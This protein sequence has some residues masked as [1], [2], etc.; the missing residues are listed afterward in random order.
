MKL[1][2]IVLLCSVG[3][4]SASQTYSQQTKLD[5]LYERVS[6]VK[7]LEDLRTQTGYHFFYFDGVVPQDVFVTIDLRQANINEILNEILVKNGFTYKI[8]E[9]TVSIGRAQTPHVQTPRVQTPQAAVVR[10]KVTEPDGTPIIGVTVA[11]KGMRGGT[12]TDANGN[13]TL[14]VPPAD[15]AILVFS[16]IGKEL[17]EVAYTGQPEIT[18]TMKDVAAAIQEV[19]VTGIF[20]RRRDSF[21]GSSNTIS[22]EEL[23][24]LSS[25]NILRAVEMLDPGFRMDVNNMYGSN[26]SVIPQFQMRGQS[27][28]GD[29]STDGDVIFRGDLDTHPN[30]PLFVLD[31]MIVEVTKIIDLDPAQ[32]QSVTVLKDAAAMVLYGSRGANGI[33][34][35]E[36]KSPQQGSLRVSYNGNYKYLAPNLNGYNLLNAAEKLQLEKNAGIYEAGTTPAAINRLYNDYRFRMLDVLRGVDTYW[37]AKPL[38]SAFN[39]RHGLNLEGGDNTLRYKLYFGVNSAPGVMKKT[40]VE[41]KSGSIDLRYRYKGLLVSNVMFVDHTVSNRTSPYGNFTEYA[42]MNP[43]YRYYDLNGNMQRYLETYYNFGMEY[44]GSGGMENPAWDSLLKQKNQN[45]AFEVRNIFRAEYLV[46]ENLR[47]TFDATISRISSDTDVFLPAEHSSFGSATFLTPELRGS[48]SWTHNTSDSFNTSLMASYNK[49]F[50]RHL[51]AVFARAE[52][53]QRKVRI[54]NN[55]ATGFPNENMDDIFLGARANDPT[56]SESTYRSI[57]TVGT[58]SYSYD[59]RYAFDF[60]GRID[61][62]S[63]FGRNNRFAPFW[64]TGLRWNAHNENFLR[65]SK[66]INELVLRGTYGITG[67]Q[68]F[69]PYQALQMYTYDNMMYVYNGSDVLGT[70]IRSLGN[71]DLKWQKTDNYNLG[72]DFT[73]FDRI[74]SGRFEYYYKY[75]KNT[76]LDFSLAPSIGFTEIVDNMGNISNEG[77]EVTLRVMPYNNP[78]RRLNVSIVAMGGHNKN[79]IR[80]ISNALRVRNEESRNSTTDRPLPR[81]EEGY[82]MSRIWVVKSLGIDPYDG[83]EVFLTRDGRMTNIYNSMDQIPYGDTEPTLRGSLN[84]NVNWKGF[85]LTMGNRYQFGGQLFNQTLIDKVE[86][87]NLRYNV[88]RRALTE[89]W[90]SQGE[91]TAFKGVS[92]AAAGQSTRASSRFVMNNNEFVLS[93]INLQYRFESRFNPFIKRMGLSSASVGLYME[94]MGRLSTIKMERGINYPFTNSVSM[95]LNLVF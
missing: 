44:S 36:T 58:V 17:V 71:P 21:T 35:V 6:L 22:G 45:K 70:V 43:Y 49:M 23:S 39:H 81:Y 60:S 29:Y 79:T 12:I 61:A 33:V 55:F 3:T 27:N 10:G 75:T 54:A 31:G 91:L 66:I 24:S 48:Y 52:I 11:L 28:M 15:R 41:G 93:T 38:T 85:S 88:D 4:L 87:A 74:F 95:S 80:S 7:V 47:L 30:Q 40:G 65:D 2:L 50:G 64:T 57:G 89:R 20:D 67:S 9:D 26:P 94:D 42:R 90:Q 37:L 84:L 68:G 8:D 25:G 1:K 56:G 46:T 77:Y 32:V 59:R 18:V 73:L 72:L 5:V 76:L 63:E 92:T 82:S 53:N 86:N 51:L 62:S 14:Q 78:A 19:V 83:R 16:F 13:F 69:T 34:V